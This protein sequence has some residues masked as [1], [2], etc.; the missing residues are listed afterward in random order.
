MQLVNK[1]NVSFQWFHLGDCLVP[2]CLVLDAVCWKVHFFSSYSS[3]RVLAVQGWLLGTANKDFLRISVPA[4]I[5]PLYEPHGTVL[6]P[7][8]PW[9]S[10]LHSSVLRCVVV[11]FSLVHLQ[12][13]LP[14]YSPHRCFSVPIFF[15]FFSS[16][17]SLLLFFCLHVGFFFFFPSFFSEKSCVV[18][19]YAEGKGL[20]SAGDAEA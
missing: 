4:A 1:E 8:V 7:E 9:P 2:C 13:F 17:S 14:Y 19:K 20:M 18:M 6:P 3:V 12:K 10:A 16:S 15:F 5:T 11:C